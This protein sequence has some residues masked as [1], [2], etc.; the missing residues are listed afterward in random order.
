MQSQGKH[1]SVPVAGCFP[2]GAACL[3]VEPAHEQNLPGETAPGVTG[4]V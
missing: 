2:A 4:G 1:L 3:R